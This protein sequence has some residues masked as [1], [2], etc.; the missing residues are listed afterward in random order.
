M[1][2]EVLVAF[3]RQLVSSWMDDEVLDACMLFDSIRR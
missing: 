3:D 1:F 2:L